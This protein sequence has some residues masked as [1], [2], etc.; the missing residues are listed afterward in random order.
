MDET[1]YFE[2]KSEKTEG[3]EAIDDID[4]FE[5]RLRG[6]A[7]AKAAAQPPLRSKVRSRHKLAAATRPCL[8]FAD[9]FGA[10]SATPASL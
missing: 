3:R 2:E 10:A 4:A 9:G 6:E 1:Y 5:R 7:P 8:I